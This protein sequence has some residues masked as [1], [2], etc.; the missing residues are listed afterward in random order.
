MVSLLLVI[1]FAYQDA[2]GYQMW[3]EAG[4]GFGSEGYTAAEPL[5]MDQFWNFAFVAIG[6]IG[7]VFYVLTK[8]LKHTFAVVAIPTVLTF[9]GWED[10]FYY[11]ITGHSFIGTTMP[12]LWN[13]FFMKGVAQFMGLATITANSLM[14]SAILG[15]FISVGIYKYFVEGW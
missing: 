2:I 15:L 9:S 8:N 6:M 7:I 14:V 5:Y 1:F 12:W 10:I 13:N 4:G 3:Q 11:V